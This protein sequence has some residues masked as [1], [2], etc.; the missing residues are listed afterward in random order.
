VWTLLTKP[1]M[2][3]TSYLHIALFYRPVVNFTFAFDYWLWGLNP[4]GYHLTNTLLHG[5]TAVLVVIT[6]R[7]LTASSRAG[8]LTGILFAV[9]PLSV[10]TVPAIARRQDILMAIFGLLTLWLFAEALRREESHTQWL[11]MGATIAYA[12]ALLSKETA[13]VL[14]PLV[15]LWA[16][17]QQSS[18]RDLRAYRQVMRDV[19]PL[20]GVAVAYLAVRF[21][22][23][24]GIGGYS[25]S[26]SLST[27][28][29]MPV[30]YVL[31]LVYPAHTFGALAEV[32]VPLFPAFILGVSVAYLLLL[33]RGRSLRE[34]ARSR[35]VVVAIIGFVLMTAMVL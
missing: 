18:L 11:R 25:R 8:V 9:H 5:L 17:L 12:L 20:V 32:S 28:L 31:A 27:M 16:V 35:L 30:R 1:L 2:Y 22:V 3:G 23:L 34:L 29:L 33:H 4:F 7:S 21:I 19:L 26:P 24:G 15:F 6:V 10:D 14:G 13:V